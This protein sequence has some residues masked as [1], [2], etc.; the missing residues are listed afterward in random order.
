MEN[1]KK[2][3]ITFLPGSFANF[4]GTQEEL[5]DLVAEI[6]RLAES[7]E[8]MDNSEIVDLETLYE[9]EPEQALMIA[10]QMGLFEGLQDPETGEELDIDQIMQSMQGTQNSK[11]N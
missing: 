8:I 1:D 5:D 9:T 3:K 10:N 2:L 6:T 11:L 4:D 7:G